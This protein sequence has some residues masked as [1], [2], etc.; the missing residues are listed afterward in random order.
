MR[1]TRLIAGTVTAGLLGLTPIAIAAPSQATENLGSTP[2][3]EFPF[4]EPGEPATYGD[5]VTIRG[6]VTG[7]DGSSSYDGTVTLYQI[8]AANPAGVA[9][10]TVPASGYLA[11]PE[12]KATENAAF[13]AAMGPAFDEAFA[14]QTGEDGKKL[15]ELVA[16]LQ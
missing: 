9:V 12:I 15:L 4:L 8:T 5:T 2:T 10:A 6:A 1:I 13:K 14:K 3:L 7:T 16:K 11:F